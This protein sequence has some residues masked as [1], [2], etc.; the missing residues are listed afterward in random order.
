MTLEHAAYMVRCATLNLCAVRAE[1][2]AAP[3]PLAR[4]FAEWDYRAA[5][6]NAKARHICIAPHGALDAQHKRGPHYG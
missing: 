3:T 2:G 5:R 4:R 6:L 1:L